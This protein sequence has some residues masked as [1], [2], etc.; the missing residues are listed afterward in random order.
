[1][2]ATMDPESSAFH[3][4]PHYRGTVSPRSASARRASVR[5]LHPRSLDWLAGRERALGLRRGEL[6]ADDADQHVE[7]E[8]LGRQHGI[9][10]AVGAPG[11][12]SSRRSS[13]VM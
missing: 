1:M 2:G 12:P 6:G 5:D 9:G 7:L 3:I 13:S 11:R 4:G 10:A 8:A